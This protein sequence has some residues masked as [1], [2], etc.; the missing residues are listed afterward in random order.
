MA[1]YG[2]SNPKWE[3]MS[4]R[5]EHVLLQ[6]PYP[7]DRRFQPPQATDPV[8]SLVTEAPDLSQHP[9]EVEIPSLSKQRE[10]PSLFSL[11]TCQADYEPSDARLTRTYARNVGGLPFE[12]RP[13]RPPPAILK[14]FQVPEAR[15]LDLIE[16]GEKKLGLVKRPLGRVD[17]IRMTDRA[18]GLIFGFSDE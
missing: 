18:D 7:G 5:K 12:T 4:S 2:K 6:S 10:R 16:R 17:F 11:P 15:A 3:Y 8:S 14:P 13:A 9:N 1:K